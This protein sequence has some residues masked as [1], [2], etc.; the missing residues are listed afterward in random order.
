M[1]KKALFEDE[2]IAGMQR[3][4]QAHEKKQGMENLVKAADYLHSAMD[5][6]EEAGL[7]V[8]AEG[9]FKILSKI[10]AEAHKP[11]HPKNPLNIHDPHTKG[12]TPEKQVKNILDHG[13][14]FNMA[15][16]G[17]ADDLLNADIMDEG[18]EVAEKDQ[19]EMDFEDEV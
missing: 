14:Q 18:L 9:I 4:L 11:P 12:L 13:T 5:I 3:E 2:L 10:A 7:T 8:Q 16:D 17:S 15:D 6:L 1:I 19:P